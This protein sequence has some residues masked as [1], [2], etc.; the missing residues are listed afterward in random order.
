MISDSRF[1]PRCLVAAR[2]FLFWVRHC[3]SKW[4]SEIQ[5]G[6]WN[7]IPAPG[8]DDSG[9]RGCERLERESGVSD[10]SLTVWSTCMSRGFS[11]V[12]GLK[13]SETTDGV[14]SFRAGHGHRGGV[15]PSLA[16]SL[17]GTPL[18]YKNRHSNEF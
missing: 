2:G 18:Q 13:R 3:E 16:H 8:T 12:T 9:T 4:R 10:L 6:V 11:G 17:K 7:V 15:L 1:P 14:F 5:R